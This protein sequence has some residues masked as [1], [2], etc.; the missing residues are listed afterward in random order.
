MFERSLMSPGK[1]GSKSMLRGA[2]G[3]N[4]VLLDTLNSFSS[5][6]PLAVILNR[7]SEVL[8]ALKVIGVERQRNCAFKGF[9]TESDRR[10]I[11]K[12]QIFFVGP[13]V[14][15][16]EVRKLHVRFSISFPDILNCMISGRHP[17][18]Q[19]ILWSISDSTKRHFLI[20]FE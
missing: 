19:S 12:V 16:V 8:N 13:D 15:I 7:I 1:K 10:L 3:K 9:V 20:F 6:A 5:S 4:L 17:S 2:L 11:I 18:V 14:Y